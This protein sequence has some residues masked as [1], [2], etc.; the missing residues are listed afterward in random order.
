[1]C[2]TSFDIIEHLSE[3]AHHLLLSVENRDFF[4]IGAV[5]KL[6]RGRRIHIITELIQRNLVTREDFFESGHPRFALTPCGWRAAQLLR[7]IAEKPLAINAIRAVYDSD[8]CPL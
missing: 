5:P 6:Q 2:L 7:E 3:P 8:S 1:M 4:G